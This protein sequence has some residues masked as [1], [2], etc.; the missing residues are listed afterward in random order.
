M[1]FTLRQLEV[2]VAVARSG[3]VSA[4]SRVLSLSQSAASSALGE[5]ERQFDRPLFDRVGKSVQLNDSGRMLLPRAVEL[6]DRAGEVEALLRGR[7]AYGS[8]R[9]GATL[10]IGNYLATLIVADFLRAHP[11]SQ[12]RLEVHNTARIVEQLLNFE[13][14]L[15]LVEGQCRAPELA[16][17]TW[18]A[19][20]LVVFC[21]P[22]HPL[23][24]HRVAGLQSLDGQPWILREQ[25]SG[26]RETFEQ[27]IR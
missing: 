13:L 24:G 3:S 5:L 1:R 21:A 8:I 4:A 10:T 15:G 9:I 17:E 19:D 25:G 16:V 26:T 23:A 27:A 6:L 18:V 7:T 11:E 12:A 20:E 14:D 2:F 22:D